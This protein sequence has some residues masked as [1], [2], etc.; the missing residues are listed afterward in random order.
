MNGSVEFFSLARESVDLV[1]DIG[2]AAV[3]AVLRR[4]TQQRLPV[5][6]PFVE[7]QDA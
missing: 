6:Q 4:V 3:I 7:L 1:F 2:D 5:P